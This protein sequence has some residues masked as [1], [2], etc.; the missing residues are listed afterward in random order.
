MITTLVIATLVIWTFFGLVF[1]FNIEERD[2]QP[3]FRMAVVLG[4]FLVVGIAVVL[5][6][7][8]F[9]EKVADWVKKA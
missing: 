7:F 9:L 2:L 6:G 5:A 1:L 4:P 8:L 3:S